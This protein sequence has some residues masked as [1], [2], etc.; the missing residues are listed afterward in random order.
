MPRRRH[1]ILAAASVVLAARPVRAAVELRVL[2]APAAGRGLDAA[3]RSFLAEAGPDKVSEVRIATAPLPQLRE[4]LAAGETADLVIGTVALINDLATAGR[5]AGERMVLGRVGI[6]VA[7][8][9]DAPAPP[10]GDLAALRRAV[11]EAEAVVVSDEPGVRTHLERLFERMGIAQA[12]AAKTVRMETGTAAMR[13]LLAG[14]GREIGFAP[15]TEIRQ[16]PGLRLA[17]PLPPEAQIATTY[18]ASLMP[19]A[20]PEAAA[21]LE[22]LNG[23]AGRAALAQSGIE[24]VP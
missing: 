24:P 12:V 4:R 13:R 10:L 22:H 3:A 6:G 7:L 9:P 21:F 23:P 5:L 11:E 18:A 2:S 14:K 15:I 16:E 19:G 1:L 17:G 20:P 8:R